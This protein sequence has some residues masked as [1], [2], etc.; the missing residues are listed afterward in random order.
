MLR[1]VYILNEGNIIYEK[2]FGK[3][4]TFENFQSI[5]QEIEAEVSRGLLDD[6][7]STHFF[8]YRVVYFQTLFFSQLNIRDFQTFFSV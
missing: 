6:F 5:Y 3:V 1:Q 4:L 7:G 2:D 8:K